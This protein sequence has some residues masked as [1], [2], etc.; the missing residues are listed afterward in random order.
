MTAG[1]VLAPLGLALA[2]A[3][4]AACAGAYFGLDRVSRARLEHAAEEDPASAALGDLLKSPRTLRGALDFLGDLARISLAVTVGASFI[5]LVDVD[6][7]GAG[8]RLAMLAAGVFVAAFYVAE[9]TPRTLAARNAEDVTRVLGGPLKTL[10]RLTSPVRALAARLMPRPT[11]TGDAS[12]G[13]EGTPAIDEEE[14][15][16]LVDESTEAGVVQAQEQALIHKILDFGDRR[17]RELMT[18]FDR[19]F[20][21]AEDTPV[22]PAAEAVAERKYSRIP[23][24]RKDPR[25]I[26]GVVYA[27]DLLAI[28]WG[29]ASAKPLKVLLRRPLFVVPQMRAQTLL[30][31]FRRH[32]LHMAIVVD[33]HGAA[34][35]VCTMEDL[36]EELVGPITDVA[37]ER[38]GDESGP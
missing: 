17:V 23:V 26:V 35:G 36:L 9:L 25:R 24:F 32:R 38:K 12:T 10:L 19:V 20:S 16:E 4:I 6:A 21:V 2:V 13:T 1:E 34:V 31:S 27:K 7:A 3:F 28:R 22:S 18:P 30:E 33:E 11:S 29:V 5:G 15:R 37:A 14:F 8:G